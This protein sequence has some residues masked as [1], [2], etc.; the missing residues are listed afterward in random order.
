MAS[1]SVGTYLYAV[2]FVNSTKGW[3]FLYHTDGEYLGNDWCS[4]F[5][6]MENDECLEF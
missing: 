6:L 3:H 1:L 2:S 4:D 5:G